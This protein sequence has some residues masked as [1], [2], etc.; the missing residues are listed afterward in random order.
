MPAYTR[1]DAVNEMLE[2]SGEQPVA[3]L[4]SDGTN[5]VSLAESVLDKEILKIQSRGLSFNTE[6]KKLYKDAN[7]KISL[8]DNILDLV[9]WNG[10]LHCDYVQRGKFLY[11][12]YNNRFTFPD[13]EY[14]ELKITYKLDFEDIPTAIQEW[15]MASAARNYQMQTQRSREMDAFLAERL[16]RAQARAKAYDARSRNA[17]YNQNFNGNTGWG[18]QRNRVGF[19]GPR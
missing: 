1:L 11:D 18:T 6:V 5:D 10:N 16:Q 15:I 3:T 9:P 17:N 19:R 14:V 12:N 7:N 13:D 8:S 4:V 2:A